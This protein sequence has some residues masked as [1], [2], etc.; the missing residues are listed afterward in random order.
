V[1]LGKARA[2]AA[3]LARLVWANALFCGALAAG[4]ALRAL[5]ML[6]YPGVTWFYGDSYVYLATALRPRPNLTKTVGYSFYLRALEPLHSFTLVAAT[7]HLMGLATAVM[8]YVLLRRARLPKWGATLATL[9]VL[10]D[11][12]VIQLEHMVM[13]E[14]V[15]TFS[16]AVAVTLVMWRD[17]RGGRPGP[18]WA[19][20]AAGLLLGYA[21]IVRAVAL[22]LLVLLV[23]FLAIRRAGWRPV[24]AAVAG[25]AI[26]IALYAAW[27][28]SWNGQYALTRSDGF[29]LWG[30]VSSFAQCAAIDPPASE[31][32]LCISKPVGDR[33]PPGSIIWR[34]YPPRHLPGGPVTPANNKLMRDFA[35]RAIVA[36]PGGYAL[37]VAHDIGRAF[38]WRRLPYPNATTA[39]QYEFAQHPPVIP[40]TR[41]W[42][43]GATTAQDMRTYGG[44]TASRVVQ[45]YARA[46]RAYQKRL[47]TPGPLLGLAMLAGLV[48]VVRFWRRLGGPV[49]FPWLTASVLL[50]FP[51]AT[52]DFSYRYL[53]PVLPFAFLAA[54]LAFVR[55]QPAA[56][57]PDS[58]E[59][60][61]PNLV[62]PVR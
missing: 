36:Q 3:W 38:Y 56:E 9:P 55:D 51:I 30:R 11:P 18:W 61:S 14:T 17:V 7:A 6:A 12:Y 21:V 32:V 42:I 44:T 53:I 16:I 50:V 28:H 40:L 49:L 37:S 8:V 46:L 13:S 23:I 58:V 39:N 4:A 62:K 45:P 10:L 20:L 43:P 31:R 1:T 60:T 26:P 52:A 22:P 48:G 29:F 41:A 47:F 33:P 54:A 57:T 19:M 24:V 59:A 2:A 25:G 5:T 34:N 15:F 35:I 27:F